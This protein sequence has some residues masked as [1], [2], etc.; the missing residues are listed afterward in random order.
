M[1]S[2]GRLGD[3]RAAMLLNV[4]IAV[5]AHPGYLLQGLAP[6]EDTTADWIGSTSMLNDASAELPTACPTTTASAF[7]LS[8]KDD[9]L[10]IM[11]DSSKRSRHPA[12]YTAA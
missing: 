7:V 1:R 10:N 3:G 4:A 5:Q 12:L 11:K 2:R 8:V 6:R 9:S